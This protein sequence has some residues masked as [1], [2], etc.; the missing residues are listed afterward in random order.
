M[1][2][3]GIH[4]QLGGGFCRYCVDA[5]VDDPALRE[6]ALRQRAAARRSTP[7][8]RASTGDAAFA[9]VARG[10]VG[11][12]VR[13][14]RAPDGAFYSSLDADSE[15]EEGKFYVWTRRRGRAPR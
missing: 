5:R 2:D 6:D 15:G 11:W 3:G 7:I 1:A 14:M 8:S 12:L 9:D 10:I 4:D 13:E